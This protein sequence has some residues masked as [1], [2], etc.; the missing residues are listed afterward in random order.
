[1]AKGMLAGDRKSRT[2]ESSTDL[3]L[4]GTSDFASEKEAIR[5]PS[6]RKSP[7]PPTLAFDSA[8]TDGGRIIDDDLRLEGVWP[9]DGR[10][11][12]MRVVA[13]DQ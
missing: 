2:N 5:R 6:E 1:M 13:V 8:P 7:A 4:A 9:G 3:S 12:I 11:R 10:A